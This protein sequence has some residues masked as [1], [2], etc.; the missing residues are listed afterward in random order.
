VFF[1]H[2]FGLGKFFILLIRF[3]AYVKVSNIKGIT[4]N[5][6]ERFGEENAYV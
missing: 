2:N 3:F 6:G 1:N 4:I 5:K